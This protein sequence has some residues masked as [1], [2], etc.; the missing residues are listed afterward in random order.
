MINNSVY[1]KHA[2]KQNERS[3]KLILDLVHYFHKKLKGKSI[4]EN[5]RINVS[6]QV[7]ASFPRRPLSSRRQSQNCLSD[8]GDLSGKDKSESNKN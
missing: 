8:V 6:T 7:D 2:V 1:V 3:I 5:R 4:R